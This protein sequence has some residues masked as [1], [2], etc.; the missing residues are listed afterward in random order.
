MGSHN[1]KL[2]GKGMYGK[3]TEFML[4]KKVYTKPDILG[5]LKKQGL[6]EGA[7]EATATVMLSP[8]LESTRGDCRGNISNPWGHL[9][10]NEPLKVVVN[11]KT[12][13][14]EA[15]RYRLRRREKAMEPRKRIVKQVVKAEK[16][17]V[18]TKTKTKTKQ[19]AKAR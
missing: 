18:A 10:Y 13:K 17:K 14:R 2:P 3:V 16:T 6:K 15:Q 19:R 12:G 8:R 5:F 4:K 7:A 1:A 11:K 9:A